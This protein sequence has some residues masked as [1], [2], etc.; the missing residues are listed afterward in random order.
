MDHLTLATQALIHTRATTAEL[1]TLASKRA[2]DSSIFEESPPFF[3]MAEISNS[4]LDAY[5]TRMA[6]STLKN[7]AAEAESGVAFQNSHNVYKL[8]FGRSISG[9]FVGAGGNGLTRV[10]ADFYTI[11]D[12]SLHEVNTNDFIRG[13]RSGLISDVS[14]GFHGGSCLC[15]ICGN[16]MFRSWDCWHCPG[17]TYLVDRPSGIKEEVLCT[18]TIEDAHLAEVSA[19]YDGATPG[20]AIRKAQMEA[21]AGRLNETQIRLLEQRYRLRLPEHPRMVAGATLPKE[22]PM[23]QTPETRAAEP[24]AETVTAAEADARTTESMPADEEEEDEEDERT[25]ATLQTRLTAL[26]SERDTVQ[27]RL[28]ATESRLT[29][30]QARIVTLEAEVARL[31]PLADDGTTYRSD[32]V[33]QAL[34]EG[35]RAMG[36][37]FALETYRAL[38]TN[39]ALP[40]I[41][42]MRDDWAQVAS[43]LYPTKRQTTGSG[44]ETPP[45]TTDRTPN[46]AYTA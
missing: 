12:L 21:Q 19:V 39:A 6:T 28:A 37:A 29:E 3:W 24:V 35:V 1:V 38:L 7:F 44:D 42:R 16:D 32:L 23:A 34:A 26:T 46:A 36:T 31:T 2:L 13:V 22:S 33:E 10:E 9:T 8:G 45:P 43:T 27:T 41:K 18:A 11:P 5:Y 4:R 20:A 25:V 17:V 15:D 14:V 40:V 30:S